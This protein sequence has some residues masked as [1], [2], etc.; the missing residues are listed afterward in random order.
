MVLLAALGVAA[1]DAL[2]QQDEPQQAPP[3][4]HVVGA[5]V[6]TN[7]PLDADGAI[8]IA[9]DRYLNP[10]TVNRQGIGLRDLF[11]N[12]PLN[13]LVDY[14]P[15]TRVVTLSNPNPGQPFLNDQQFYELVF[16]VA[17]VGDASSFGLVAIDGATI[18]P[19]TPSI[20]FEVVS[21]GRRPPGLRPTVVTPPP[22]INFCSD[23][24]PL[25]RVVV[26]GVEGA[27]GTGTCHGVN[28]SLESAM[29]L[30]LTTEEGIRHTAIGVP[31]VETTTAGQSTAL[32][33][34]SVFPVGMPIIDPGYPGNSYLLYKLLKADDVD[35]SGGPIP[36]TACNPTTTPFPYGPGLGLASPDEDMRLADLIPGRRMPWGKSPLTIDEMERIRA[37]ILQGA[38]V[39]DC[40]MCYASSP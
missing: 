16:P 37:W 3:F 8:Q 4:I 18:D 12:A 22:P 11:G 15:I 40:T 28:S 21:M 31:A 27:C 5:N 32:P 13:P 6:G 2:S 24:M 30:V 17:T 20:S 1:C 29:G 34:Q 33:P 39:D 25:F 23:V 7:Q 35:G 9:F 26:S 38:R 14:D 10:S 36:Y 19:A